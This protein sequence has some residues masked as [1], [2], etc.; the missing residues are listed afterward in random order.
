[1]SSNNLTKFDQVDVYYSFVNDSVTEVVFFVAF[2]L[3]MDISAK[4]CRFFFCCYPRQNDDF[5]TNNPLHKGDVDDKLKTTIGE[6]S[7]MID[8]YMLKF[9]REV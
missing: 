3:F 8:L 6:K 9:I 2:E 4:N 7:S 1:M 5:Y